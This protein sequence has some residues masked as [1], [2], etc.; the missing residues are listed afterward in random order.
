MKTINSSLSSPP[1][2]FRSSMNDCSNKRPRGS[3]NE[4]IF[5]Q[6]TAPSLRHTIERFDNEEKP[7]LFSTFLEQI[8]CVPTK[9]I[10]EPREV[11]YPQCPR[12]TT[13]SPPLSPPV[14]YVH[15]YRRG[16]ATIKSHDTE[17]TSNEDDDDEESASSSLWLLDDGNK[18]RWLDVV[19]GR[20][21]PVVSN[22]S[23]SRRSKDDSSR[24]LRLRKSVCFDDEDVQDAPHHRRSILT[25]NRNR[26]AMR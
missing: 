13:P 26:I 11:R 8:T 15:R 25:D 22:I 17:A 19:D 23:S 10:V 7:S 18:R 16:L 1:S 5:R 12:T 3:S 9:A 24:S 14:L 2:S 21:T 20:V 6:N 4:E